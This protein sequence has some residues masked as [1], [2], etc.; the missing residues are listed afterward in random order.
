MRL[1]ITSV[2]FT[3]KHDWLFKLADENGIE[4]FIMDSHF[5]TDHKLPSPINKH[6]LDYYEKGISINASIK[7]V[8]K[9]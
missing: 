3:Q 4:Y 8:D 5:Y 7:E 9:Y 2:N 6:Y 1:K